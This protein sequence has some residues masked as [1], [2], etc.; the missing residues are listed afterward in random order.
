MTEGKIFVRLDQSKAKEKEDQWQQL[1]VGCSLPGKWI[2]HW[3]VSYVDDTGSEWDQPPENMRPPG[4][5]PV[6]VNLIY[7]FIEF[8]WPWHLTV[9]GWNVM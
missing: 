8:Q 3:G 7:L 6:K 5:I 2:L 4:S 9:T 1:T